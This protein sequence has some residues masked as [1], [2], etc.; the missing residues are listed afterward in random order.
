MSDVDVRCVTTQ[1]LHDLIGVSV[2]TLRQ[3]R[4]NGIGPKS[5]KP[6]GVVLYRLRD[7]EAW[8]EAAERAE[9]AS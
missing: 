1:Q 6:H 5:S 9:Q 2:G 4:A 7:V 8:L 3:W